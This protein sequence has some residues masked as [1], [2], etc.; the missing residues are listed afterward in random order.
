M[1]SVFIWVQAVCSVSRDSLSSRKLLANRPGGTQ[2]SGVC[3]SDLGNTTTF[4]ALTQLLWASEINVY[5]LEKL[6]RIRTLNAENHHVKM[7]Q[8]ENVGIA[9]VVKQ[10]DLRCFVSSTV[11]SFINELIC[12][13]RALLSLL[14]QWSFHSLFCKRSSCVSGRVCPILCWWWRLPDFGRVPTGWPIPP[15]LRHR[16]HS[17][18]THFIT[19]FVCG[20]CYFC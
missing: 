17:P 7:Y 9:A 14:L 4:T 6:G 18:V 2:G 12:E 11:H 13:W 8:E 10:L 19:G 16:A 3:S 20:A 5:L 1:F 15:L